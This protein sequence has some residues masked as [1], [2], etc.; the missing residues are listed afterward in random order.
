MQPTAFLAEASRFYANLWLIL[1]IAFAIAALI[2]LILW[3]L[4]SDSVEGEATDQSAA[5]KDEPAPD[6]K[7]KA[8]PEPGED[9]S[10]SDEGEENPDFRAATE[11]EAASL[12]AE[13]LSSGLV[14]QDPVYGIIYTEAPGEADDL[15]RIKGV[16]KVLEGKLNGIGVYRFKQ[17][18]VWTDAACEEFS[19][20]LTFK[21]RIWTDNWLAQA[22]QLHEEKYGEKIE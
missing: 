7:E 15:K 6:G 21:K 14:K 1:A 8:E 12:F 10:R 3:L 19:K 17:V 18:A 5:S 13:E 9:E 4:S 16:A 22:K 2:W 11:E 20:M